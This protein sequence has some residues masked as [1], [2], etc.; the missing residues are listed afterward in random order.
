MED[1]ELLKCATAFFSHTPYPLD[2]LTHPVEDLKVDL[3]DVEFRVWVQTLQFELHSLQ[4]RLGW[5]FNEQ[6]GCMWTEITDAGY[7]SQHEQAGGLRS[8]G[9]LTS[10]RD[11]QLLFRAT[12]SKQPLPLPD[13]CFRLPLENCQYYQSQSNYDHMTNNRFFHFTVTAMTEAICL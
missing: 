12:L 8:E 3:A 9:V 5:P 7:W 4:N 6:S 11:L 2:P 10:P 1:P 13:I